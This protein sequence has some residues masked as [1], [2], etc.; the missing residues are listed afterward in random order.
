VCLRVLP[1]VHVFALP[2]IPWHVQI[3]CVSLSD[4]YWEENSSTLQYATMAQR[5]ANKPSVNEDPRVKMIRELQKEIDMLKGELKRVRPRRAW[6]CQVVASC[7]C[8]F[9]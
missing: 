6:Q 7:C 9:R 1:N 4:E 5:I 8:C 3:A 2:T